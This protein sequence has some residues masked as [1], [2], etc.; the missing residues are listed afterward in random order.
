VNRWKTQAFG[1][2][3]DYTMWVGE[4]GPLG[5]V[6]KLPEEAKKMGAPPHWMGNVQVESVDATATL[7]KK[8]GG[9][10]YK[11]ASDIPEVGR[12]AVI[13]DPQGASLSIFQPT[14]EMKLHDAGK[15]GEVCWNEL[16]T[17]D[18]VA[19]F[20]FY[21][22]I[23]GWKTLQ[24]MD[25]GPM[26]TYQIYGVGDVGLG[27][28][29]NKP[30][31]MKMPPAWLFYFSTPDLDAALE[32]SKKKDAKLLMGPMDIPEGRIA[33]LMDPQGAAYAIHQHVPKKK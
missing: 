31:E 11:E 7:V 27:G 1:Q 33:N 23:F 16:L 25:M 24:E 28:I 30:A 9:K 29:M 21:S 6:M 5:G 4:Q 14:G 10:I 13:A 2:G 20:K 32:R 18:R 15:E 17:T 12:F 8:L 22:E 3:T 19:A 26:G